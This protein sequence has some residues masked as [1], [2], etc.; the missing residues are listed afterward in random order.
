MNEYDFNIMPTILTDFIQ[1]KLYDVNTQPLYIQRFSQPEVLFE[2]EN[3][4]FE[5]EDLNAAF[6]QMKR[7]SGLQGHSNFLDQQTF[8]NLMINLFKQRKIPKVWSMYSFEKI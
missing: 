8:L 2:T 6:E 5:I 3:C 1:T 4:R 7:A